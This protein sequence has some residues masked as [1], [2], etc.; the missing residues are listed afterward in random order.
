MFCSSLRGRIEW[1]KVPA[2]LLAMEFP[3]WRERVLDTYDMA[4]PINMQIGS[5]GSTEFFH[6]LLLSS[7]DLK[8]SDKV[9]TRTQRLFYSQGGKNIGIIF[10]LNEQGQEENGPKALMTLQNSILSDLEMPVLLLFGVDSL[11]AT[12]QVFQEQFRQS[13]RSSSQKDISAITLLPFCSIHPPIPKY[14]INL[15]IDICLN[16]S[17]LLELVTTREGIEKLTIVLSGFPGLA[18]DIISFWHN[19]YVAD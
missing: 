7:F 8:D 19:D 3:K 12:I 5:S 11:E 16:I 1:N 15:L 17:S 13:S 9:S 4:L 14:A 10:L 6:F 2:T 18:Q